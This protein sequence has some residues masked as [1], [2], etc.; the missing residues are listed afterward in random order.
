MLPASPNK[1]NISS[2]PLIFA[3]TSE[4]SGW[5][6]NNKAATNGTEKNHFFSSLF[7]LNS[8][9]LITSSTIKLWYNLW[10]AIGCAY[11]SEAGKRL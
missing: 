7:S 2:R 10:V 4:C 11:Q 9:I 6:I 8:V 5:I 1:A 3:T